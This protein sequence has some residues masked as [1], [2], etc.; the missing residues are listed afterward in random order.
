MYCIK[1][2]RAKLKE[3]FNDSIYFLSAAG[4]RGELVC[5]RDNIDKILR[6]VNNTNENTETSIITAAAKLIREKVRKMKA[7]EYYATK[8][9]I[10]ADEKDN[11]WVPDLLRLLMAEL[12]SCPKKRL[13]INQCIVMGMRPRTLIPPIPQAICI[14]IDNFCVSTQLVQELHR[15]GVS[16]SLEEVFRFK[17]SAVLSS[18]EQFQPQPEAQPQP[19]EENNNSEEG[20]ENSR[21]TFVQWVG[22]NMDH[23][24]ATL[25]GKGTFHGMDIISIKYDGDCNT[26]KQIFRQKIRSKHLQLLQKMELQ[27]NS[28]T[29][30]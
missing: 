18:E 22:D 27:F 11:A 30:P 1:A 19:E 10:C 26:N 13:C 3:R 16:I 12:I 2:L 6:E 4:R 17:A 20:P 5:F 23:N 21:N 9:E 28:T 15:V 8:T 14:S 29:A 25:T 7:S 24:T